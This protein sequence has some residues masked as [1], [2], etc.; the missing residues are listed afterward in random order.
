M[1][2]FCDGL[3]CRLHTGK[4]SSRRGRRQSKQQ[5]VQGCSTGEPH[6]LARGLLVGR[7]GRLN[8]GTWRRGFFLCIFFLFCHLC[9]GGCCS[10]W[11][12]GFASFGTLAR[13]NSSL[14]YA[15][16]RLGRAVD[17][18]FG[19]P[20]G[21]KERKKG[22]HGVVS[23]LSDEGQEKKVIRAWR[24]AARLLWHALLWFSFFSSATVT[25]PGRAVEFDGA[26]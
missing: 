16:T 14:V 11:P 19:G 15:K 13:G 12:H 20:C 18:L 2:V 24:L 17:T 8:L 5:K 25:I 22:P 1:C 6:S 4:A 26:S 21:A 3:D 9:Q 7:Q 23:V 10:A